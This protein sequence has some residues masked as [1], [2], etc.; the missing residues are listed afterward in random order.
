[1]ITAI[2]PKYMSAIHKLDYVSYSAITLAS[3]MKVSFEV[4]TDSHVVTEL[5]ALL[6]KQTDRSDDRSINMQDWYSV[7]SAVEREMRKIHGDDRAN[8]LSKHHMVVLGLATR[9]GWPVA[10]D[11]DIEQRELAYLDKSHDYSTIDHTSVAAI[12]NKHSM[13]AYRGTQPTPHAQKRRVTEEPAANPS[14]K[15]RG[16]NCFRCGSAGH[17]PASCSALTTSAGKPAAALATNAKSGQALQ[18]QNGSQYCFSFASRGSCKFGTACSFE[19]SCSLC[20]STSH[21][22]ANCRVKA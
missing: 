15:H 2:P 7:A 10:V 1:M 14:K 18:A 3:R 12:F 19:H 4:P 5:S 11:Y 16:G 17:L 8:A 13:Q 9:W 21:G 6:S 20:W 22:A